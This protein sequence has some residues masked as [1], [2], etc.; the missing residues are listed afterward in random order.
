MNRNVLD[1]SAVLA[2]VQG[3]RGAR[4]VESALDGGAVCGAANWSEVA[5][6]VRRNGADWPR[7]KLLLY[8]YA[9]AVEPVT[10]DDAERAAGLWQQG[11]GLS[12]ADRLCI[13]LGDRLE[14]I[15]LTADGDWGE[16]ERI[17]QIR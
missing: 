9:F 17:R 6:K 8:D 10:I 2:F 1:A 16:T 5:Q 11:A 3:E 7:T 12:L 4:V 13:A 14:A 15:T